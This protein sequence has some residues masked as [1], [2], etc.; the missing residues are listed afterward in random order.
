[1]KMRVNRG[2]EFVSVGYTRGALP[3]R[4]REAKSRTRQKN[5]AFKSFEDVREAGATLPTAARPVVTEA[6]GA[7]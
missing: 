5:E 6:T 7:I 4:A 1:M 3:R 2:Q